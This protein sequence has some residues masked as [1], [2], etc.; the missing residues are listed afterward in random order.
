M[1]KIT[2]YNHF[3]NGDMF[4]SRILINVLSEYYNFQFNHNLKSSLFTDVPSV[5][6]VI[7]IPPFFP[8]HENPIFN[9]NSNSPKIINTWIGQYHNKYTKSINLGCSFENH[10][11]LVSE[12]CEKLDISP[13][14]GPKFLPR[15]NSDLIPNVSR[16]NKKINSLKNNF[17]KLI[18]FCNG[19][20][21]SG[22][23]S[24]FD[25]SK[26]IVN[27]SK[28]YPDFLFILTEPI[29]YQSD[30]IIT[31]NSLTNTSPDLVHIGHISKSCD[32]IVGRSSGPYCFSQIYENLEDTNKTFC[33]FCT[34]ESEGIFYQESK[35]NYI[36]TNVYGDKNIIDNIE[37]SINF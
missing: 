23:S 13:E 22:Q 30:N 4:F 6:E 16:L 20:V 29:N 35:C 27:L 7:G 28:N 9:L 31:T 12:I 18:L 34:H 17:I 15:I 37:K 24:N 8:M 25:F 26:Y 19:N 1:D 2:L 33:A 32:V 36:W 21:H 5:D 11:N 14:F 3:H 10:F